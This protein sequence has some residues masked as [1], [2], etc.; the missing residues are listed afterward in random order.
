MMR[1]R[2]VPQVIKNTSDHSLTLTHLKSKCSLLWMHGLGDTASSYLPFF[3]HLQSPLYKKTRIKLLEAPKRFI[4]LN[5][6][7]SNAWFDM[8]SQHRLT[9]PEAKIFNLDQLD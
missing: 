1:A 8:Y 3:T 7:S 6:Q 4:S 2:R 5:H 9:L